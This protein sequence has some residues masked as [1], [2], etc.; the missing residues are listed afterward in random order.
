M[1]AGA[2]TCSERNFVLKHASQY[3]QRHAGT[4][5]RHKA[6]CCLYGGLFLLHE[7]LF[8]K[9]TQVAWQ[10]RIEISY[11]GS[12]AIYCRFQLTKAPHLVHLIKADSD[13]SRQ[14]RTSHWQKYTKTSA[15]ITL[16]STEGYMSFDATSQ[17]AKRRLQAQL[18]RF[19][20]RMAKKANLASSHC[21]SRP[22]RSQATGRAT[23]LKAEATAFAT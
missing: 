19:R 20:L 7:I 17:H 22:I 8:G 16:S 4:V 11:D 14:K 1:V 15:C 21:T 10:A 6:S 9:E 2:S 12:K 23:T 5:N 3:Q 13:A 18:A